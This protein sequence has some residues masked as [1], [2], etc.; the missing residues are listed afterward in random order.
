MFQPI[1][2]DCAGG[3]GGFVSLLTWKGL[4]H[5]ASPPSK[6]SSPAL[7][8]PEKI[9]RFRASRD[10][11]YLSAYATPFET[12]IF[13]AQSN[14][15]SGAGVPSEPAADDDEEE[16]VVLVVVDVVVSTE[17]EEERGGPS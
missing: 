7:E 1:V 3:G 11:S 10:N 5:I 17:E 12:G 4:P 13:A 6:R 14:A 9:P 16:V 15:A 8:A 2:D